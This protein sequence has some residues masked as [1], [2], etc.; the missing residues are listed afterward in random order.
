M[1]TV[2]TG[3]PT[4]IIAAMGMR[5]LID[6]LM[7]IEGL[8][9]KVLTVLGVLMAV[10]ISGSTAIAKDTDRYPGGRAQIYKETCGDLVRRREREL[11]RYYEIQMEAL[12]GELRRP[13]SR[14]RDRYDDR[15]RGSER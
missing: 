5:T 1:L 10:A 3:A 9:M 15:R 14:Y 8:K 7:V 4:R 6:V 11:K 2:G 12:R 13:E